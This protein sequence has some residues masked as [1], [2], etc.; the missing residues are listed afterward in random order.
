MLV[1]CLA[2]LAACGSI[3]E[4]PEESDAAV[5][6]ETSEADVA[7]E[8]N[9]VKEGRGVINYGYVKA[10]WVS[11][12]DMAAVLKLDEEGYRKAV[13]KMISNIRSM[14]LNTVILQIRPYGDSFY[15]SDV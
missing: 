13:A 2:F 1:L 7:V 5:S 15:E 8:S 12:F 6:T 4:G 3:A 10:I 14:G 9:E 11:Q